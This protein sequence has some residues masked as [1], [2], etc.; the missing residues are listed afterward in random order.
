MA[1]KQVYGKG[2]CLAAVLLSVTATAFA[3]APVDRKQEARVAATMSDEMTL[4]LMLKQFRKDCGRYPT[5]REGLMA[6][7]KAPKRVPNWRGPYVTRV[8]LDPWGH[9]YLYRSTEKG[10]FVLISYGADGAPGG[11]GYGRDLISRSPLVVNFGSKPAR[12]E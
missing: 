12:R 10:K 6:L 9:R 1:R 11:T 2:L 5:T 8:P 7:L 3:G 4:G